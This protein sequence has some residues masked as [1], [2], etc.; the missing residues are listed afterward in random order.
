MT[1]GERTSSESAFSDEVTEADFAVEDS[2][3]ASADF[4][5]DEKPTKKRTRS[6]YKT[7]A[8]LELDRWLDL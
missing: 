8:R 4:F 6:S 5:A 1:E 3:Y 7:K 2:A